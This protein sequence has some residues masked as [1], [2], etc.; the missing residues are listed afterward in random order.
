MY[1][2]ILAILPGILLLWYFRRK[3]HA[4]PEP[5]RY[6][7][8]TLLISAVFVI[9]VAL[10]EVGLTALT[11]LS[12][13]GNARNVFLYAL[14]VIALIEEISKA[15]AVR[16]YAYRKIEFN[17]P[18]DGLLYGAASGAGFAIL[19]NI[20]YVMEHGLAV[21]IMRAFLSVPMHV[22]TGALMGYGLLRLK[23]HASYSRFAILFTLSV[24]LHGIYDFVI[25]T[26]TVASP[27]IAIGISVGAV[28]LLFGVTRYYV[29]KYQTVVGDETPKPSVIKK[30]LW[31]ITGIMVLLA[32][33]FMALGAMVNYA[34]GKKDDM[35][36]YAVLI[37]LPAAFGIYCL[38]RSRRYRPTIITT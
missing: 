27:G 18:I 12:E 38:I 4:N 23:L 26:M 30:F 21:A 19:E 24:L 34:E 3:D 2:L 31:R 6:I 33:A 32:S 7:W 20:F 16:I 13:T 35:A 14:L 5:S 25:F 1:L 9:P 22:F 17:E 11:G 29:H 37:L 8:I 36:V 10:I 15:L 28:L